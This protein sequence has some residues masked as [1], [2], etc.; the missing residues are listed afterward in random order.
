MIV[1][2]KGNVGIGKA[3]SPDA[4]LDVGGKIKS[5]ELNI[6]GDALVVD[7]SGKVGIGKAPAKNLDVNGTIQGSALETSGN[8]KCND[9]AV[10]GGALT[11]SGNHFLE[12]GAG[13]TK[14][15]LNGKI[16]YTSDALVISGAG[17]KEDFS[18]RKI[19]LQAQGGLTV[20]GPLK[21]SA[22]YLELS[23]GNTKEANAGKIGY[24]LFTGGLDII[25]AGVNKDL[26]D[27]K[28][29]LHAQGGMV[30]FAERGLSVYGPILM[31]GF[32]GAYDASNKN[33]PKAE[34]EAK[35]K[36]FLKDAQIGVFML[37]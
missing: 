15:G 7:A 31:D 6:R 12:F 17:V 37:T 19:T 29:T 21:I 8:V 10:T 36:A 18:D 27:R 5:L 14:Q 35:V 34:V 28:I 16:W 11:I 30:V 1:D 32:V 20:E 24:Q 22:Y 2:E 26:S 13:T 25:G 3:P 23:A 4:L 9:L 33:A